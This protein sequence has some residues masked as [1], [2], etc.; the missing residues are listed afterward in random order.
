M[1]TLR[2]QLSVPPGCPSGDTTATPTRPPQRSK[3]GVSAGSL[4]CG[5]WDEL[6]MSRDAHLWGLFLTNSTSIHG[7]SCT[8]CTPDIAA[9]PVP[10]R[11]VLNLGSGRNS[12]VGGS[13][14]HSSPRFAPA[15]FPIHRSALAKCCRRAIAAFVKTQSILGFQRR[16]PACTV[17]IDDPKR[18]RT[19]QNAAS[20][21][22]SKV[23]RRNWAHRSFIYGNK[24]I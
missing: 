10:H 22:E 5:R 3:E 18:R 15:C 11:S 16:R 21:I 2:T 12:V 23:G 4:G 6:R 7:C 17:Q 13:I 19:G 8:S 9:L 14:N 1:T 24:A 20:S